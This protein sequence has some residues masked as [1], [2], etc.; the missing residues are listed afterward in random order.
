MAKC[1]AL[2]GL[3]VKGLTVYSTRTA[4][5]VIVQSQLNELGAV[6][7][8]LYSQRLT[9]SI[10]RLLRFCLI[11]VECQ[12]SYPVYLCHAWSSL[13]VGLSKRPIDWL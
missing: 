11:V 4:F 10:S 2:T 7:N 3:A 6:S 12:Y 13:H 8:P 5:L 9:A 1:K